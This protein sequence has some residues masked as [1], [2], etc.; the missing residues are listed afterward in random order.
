MRKM[1]STDIEKADQLAARIRQRLEETGIQQTELADACGVTRS[2]VSQWT[3]DGR[4]YHGHLP[5]IAR[6][7]GVSLDWLMTGERGYSPADLAWLEKIR[8]LQPADRR[9]L[10]QITD[11]FNLASDGEGG[12]DGTTGG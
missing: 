11:A 8:R 10:Q 6:K 7:L 4:I 1:T 12:A 3:R 9:R 5:T 2:A